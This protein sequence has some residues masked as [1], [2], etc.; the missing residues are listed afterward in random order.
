M[1]HKSKSLFLIFFFIFNIL[2][3]K[4]ERLRMKLVIASDHGGFELKNKIYKWLVSNNHN[5]TDLGNKIYDPKD[6]YPDFAAAL[7]KEISEGK[8]DRGIVL[9]GSGVGACVVA[10]KFKNVRAAITHDTYSAHQGVE[11]DD[12]NV[13]CIGARIIGENLALEIVEEFVKAEFQQEERFLRR[14]EKLKNIEK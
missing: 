13:I 7:G 6:D 3:C 5:V 12:M 11:H 4:N 8:A 2:N 10:N 1:H 14:L 9:C